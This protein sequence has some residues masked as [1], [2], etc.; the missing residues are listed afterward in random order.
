MKMVYSNFST[1][2]PTWLQNFDFVDL[3]FMFITLVGAGL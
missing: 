1:N 3:T 2:L